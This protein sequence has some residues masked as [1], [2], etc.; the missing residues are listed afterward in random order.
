VIGA[1]FDEPFFDYFDDPFIEHENELVPLILCPTK[2]WYAMRPEPVVPGPF[3]VNKATLFIKLRLYGIMPQG[4]KKKGATGQFISLKWSLRRYK[5][6]PIDL[7]GKKLIVSLS[8][9]L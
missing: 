5:G 4:V 2:C 1:Y 6:N 8:A 9:A 3:V 7:S